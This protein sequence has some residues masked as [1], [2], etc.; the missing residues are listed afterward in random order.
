MK[1]PIFGTLADVE[2]QELDWFW[3]PLIPFGMLTIMEGDPGIGK[4]FLTMHLAALISLGGALPNGQKVQK[5]RV[6]ILS[7]EDDP[8]Y[9]IR[10]R[11]DAMGC[12]AERIRYMAEYSPFDDDG[13]NALRTE[14]KKFEPHLIIVDPLFAFVPSASDMYKPNEIRGLLSQLG[15]VATECGAAMIVVRHLRKS[16]SGKAIYQGIGSIDVIGAARSALL[17]AVH[18]EDPE[19]RIMAHLKHN[20]APKGDSWVYELKVE[21]D[22]N[23]PVLRWHGKSQITVDDL[24]GAEPSGQNAQDA[25]MA[26]LREALKDGPKSA[27]A[28]LAK[29]VSSGHAERTID[30]ARKAIGLKAKKVKDQWMWSLPD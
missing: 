19:L 7:A 27:T 24:Q 2:P 17:V 1:K 16:N 4:S 13:L 12:D 22:G 20:L 14:V 9:T 18:P 3:E 21:G 28:V 6:L 15:A 11:L 10:P 25:A 23:I 29:A 5:G 30:R 26:F 8:S